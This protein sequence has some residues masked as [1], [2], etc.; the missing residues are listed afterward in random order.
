M[1][2]WVVPLALVCKARCWCSF[3]M[4]QT[5]GEDPDDESQWGSPGCNA[6]L[7]SVTDVVVC[8]YFMKCVCVCFVRFLAE[9]HLC[10]SARYLGMESS[11]CA[12]QS[13]KLAVI[14]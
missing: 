13:D 7:L 4:T 12:L 5:P 10:L 3:A 11:S 6:G 9:S 14:N 1:G 8:R 2:V